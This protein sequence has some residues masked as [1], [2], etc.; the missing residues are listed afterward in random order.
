[1]ADQKIQ[2]NRIPP[3]ETLSIPEKA[4]ITVLFPIAALIN[5]YGIRQGCG[6]YLE[7]GSL[8]ILAVTMTVFSIKDD[9]G[10]GRF[11]YYF[12]AVCATVVD[13]NLAW[14]G[15]YIASTLFGATPVPYLASR[16]LE[17]FSVAVIWFI[18]LKN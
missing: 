3:T 17:F 6:P 10:R 12:F 18:T 15:W 14:R 1:M 7:T 4:V 16:A 13:L 2:E 11:W 9:D 5:F 8:P